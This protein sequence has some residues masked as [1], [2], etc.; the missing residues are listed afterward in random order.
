MEA[1]VNLITVNEGERQ[2]VST[3]WQ[4]WLIFLA[5]SLVPEGSSILLQSSKQSVQRDTVYTNFIGIVHLMDSSQHCLGVS[6]G[7]L[8]HFLM[9]TSTRSGLV[10]CSILVST[11]YSFPCNW[12]WGW[13]VISAE[14]Q[15]EG[16]I[17]KFIINRRIH[18]NKS[19]FALIYWSWKRS[20][21]DLKTKKLSTK[22]HY[23]PF[24]T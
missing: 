20:L 13:Q 19:P 8:P 11:Y 14:T 3:E 18:K 10:V 4:L 21:V 23:F 22:F 17:V 1:Q 9:R 7:I 24:T 5:V 6:A 2:K 15:W 16:V 12:F